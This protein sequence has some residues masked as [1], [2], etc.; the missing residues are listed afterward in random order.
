ME[1]IGNSSPLEGVHKLRRKTTFGN[2]EFVFAD[3]NR[4][5]AEL[6]VR[7]VTEVKTLEG[8]MS[9]EDGSVG[10]EGLTVEGF[11]GG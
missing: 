1:K 2:V 6:V 11:K 4:N 10:G 5:V 7:V 9:G 8:F 3:G